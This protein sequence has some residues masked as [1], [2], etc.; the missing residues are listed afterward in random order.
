[1]TKLRE[2]EKTQHH[3]DRTASQPN[4][5]RYWYL[6]AT[7]TSIKATLAR[8]NFCHCISLVLFTLKISKRKKG[9]STSKLIIHKHGFQCFDSHVLLLSILC[10]FIS[11]NQSVI[12]TKI[13]ACPITATQ[14]SSTGEDQSTNHYR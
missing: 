13:L 14:H 8:M 6:E 2:R 1:M 3:D 4:L 10:Q 7:V 5:W 12:K 11:F 9:R